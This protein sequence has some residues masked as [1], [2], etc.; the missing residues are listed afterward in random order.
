[1]YCRPYYVLVYYPFWCESRVLINVTHSSAE[2]IVILF[3][4]HICVIW[5]KSIWRSL[6]CVYG[7]QNEMCKS[8]PK[9]CVLCSRDRILVRSLLVYVS[10]PT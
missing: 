7:Q 10:E 8:G 1:M 4:F 2:R 9:I 5:A 3:S 6:R